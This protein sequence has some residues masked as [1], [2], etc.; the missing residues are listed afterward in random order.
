MVGDDLETDIRGAQAFGMKTA[1]VRTGKFRPDSLD[2]SDV[3]PNAVLSSI[4]Q[5]PDWLE[6]GLA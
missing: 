4:A 2:H 5:L 3:V 1:L 6:R